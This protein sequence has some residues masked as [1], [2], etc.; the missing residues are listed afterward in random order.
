[1]N[2]LSDDLLLRYACEYLPYGVSIE[3]MIN[4]ERVALS[5]D[6]VDMKD[7]YRYWTE[8]GKKLRRLGVDCDARGFHPHQIKLILRPMTAMNEDEAVFVDCVNDGTKKRRFCLER[9]LDFDNIINQGIAVPAD[10]ETYPQYNP[11]VADC[12]EGEKEK[13]LDEVDEILNR[14]RNDEK[15]VFT[16]SEVREWVKSKRNA[17]AKN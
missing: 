7:T 11:T 16:W 6:R 3:T 10:I 4:K 12:I 17:G 2:E 5:L 15:S 9:K 1:M 13:L 8:D 14:L